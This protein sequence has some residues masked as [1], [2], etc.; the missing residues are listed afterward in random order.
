MYRLTTPT[1]AFNL[2]I[3]T[4]TL[5]AVYVTVKQD[6]YIVEKIL[7]DCTLEEKRL[8]VSLTQEETEPFEAGKNLE[9]QLR[10]K[11]QNGNAY[12]SRVF[13]LPCEAVLKEGVI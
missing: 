5:K 13:C 7:S 8:K 2:P 4:S 1:L 10:V 6:D 3:E 9:I 12:A 11:D